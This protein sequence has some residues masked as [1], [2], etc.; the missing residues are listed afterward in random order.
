MTKQF[1]HPCENTEPHDRHARRLKIFTFP[2]KDGIYERD[3][4]PIFLGHRTI[5]CDGVTRG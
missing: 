2:S 1:T 5:L 3:A 4:P